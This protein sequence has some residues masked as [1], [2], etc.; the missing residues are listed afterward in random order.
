MRPFLIHNMTPLI[1]T[2]KGNIPIE[3][4]QY[5]TEWQETAD[6]VRF[7]ETYKQEDEVVKRSIHVMIKQGLPVFGE[8]GQLNG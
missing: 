7:I 6:Q 3:G 4:L 2:T 8:Q 1:W 5:S